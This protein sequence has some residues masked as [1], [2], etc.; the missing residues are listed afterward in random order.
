MSISGSILM[1]VEDLLTWQL[2]DK[3]KKGLKEVGI[4]KRESRLPG[5][6][7]DVRFRTTF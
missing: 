6:K 3:L 7:L 5:Q 2:H 4:E 1:S